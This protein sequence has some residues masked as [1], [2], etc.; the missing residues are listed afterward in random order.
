MN[1]DFKDFKY[2]EPN[3]YLRISAKIFVLIYLTYSV[4]PPL[5]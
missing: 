1:A 4:S 3:K 2:K 5:T